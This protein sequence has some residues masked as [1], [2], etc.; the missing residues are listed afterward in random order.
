MPPSLIPAVELP[1]IEIMG[2]QMIVD[3]VEDD[4]DAARMGG[5]DETSQPV[6]TAVTLLDSEYVGRV[7]SPGNIGW[8]FVGRKQLDRVDAEVD[9]V[10]EAADDGVKGSP[11]VAAA[12]SEGEGADMPLIN[13]E[14]VPGGRRTP[15]R[16]APR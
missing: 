2:A 12:G 4:R 13:G 9:Q 7:V 16:R 3:H 8:K 5:V 6:R 10:I 11:S 15:G 1:Q 14:L